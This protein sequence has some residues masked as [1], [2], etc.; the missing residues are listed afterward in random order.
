MQRVGRDRDRFTA[1]ALA[2]TYE[3]DLPRERERHLNDV[4]GMW[5]GPRVPLARRRAEDP[6]ARALPKQ[7]APLRLRSHRGEL[8]CV[9]RTASAFRR[10]DEADNRLGDL[11]RP[12]D[13]QHVACTY[14]EA[15]LTVMR[16][17]GE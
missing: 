7:D 13:L 15:L 10:R 9:T 2:F 3:V 16:F 14:E 11:V 8:T 1:H 4:M 5:I 6:K 12:L 17:V